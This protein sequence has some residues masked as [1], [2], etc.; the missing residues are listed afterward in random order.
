M[1]LIKS[2]I[3]ILLFVFLSSLVWA[4]QPARQQNIIR[5][6]YF[7]NPVPRDFSSNQSTV[8]LVGATFF[9]RDPG[10][11][12]TA[13]GTKTWY[14]SGDGAI[15]LTQT[16]GVRIELP[17][18]ADLNFQ[19][20]DFTIFV[21][22][23]EEANAANQPLMTF[24]KANACAGCGGLCGWAIWQ[25][26]GQ[27]LAMA[28]CA[29]G[30]NPGPTVANIPDFKFVNGYFFRKTGTNLDF[31]TNGEK[32]GATVAGGATF[33]DACPAGKCP[34]LII[35]DVAGVNGPIE[36]TG[37]IAA[38]IIWNTSISDNEIKATWQNSK[39]SLFMAEQ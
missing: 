24:A 35:G 28:N 15:F 39:E 6:I 17:P 1:S 33:G 12:A 18:A 10:G 4:L 8:T 32:V 30:T 31:F 23:S 26:N 21:A 25:D 37:K 5:E 20:T 36:Y 22:V 14:Y 13:Y 34:P 11:Y 2:P 27:K 3:I 16:A 9:V 19:A 38:I 7:S 29:A